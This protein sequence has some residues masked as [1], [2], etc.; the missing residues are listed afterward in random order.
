MDGQKPNVKKDALTVSRPE[1]LVDG[2][3]ATFRDF[4][5]GFLTMAR[6]IDQIRESFAYHLGVSGPQYEVLVHLRHEGGADGLSVGELA[7][8][9]HCTGAF[10]TTE[11]GKLVKKGLLEKRADST[12]GRRVRLRLTA[13][14]K[15]KLREL[16]RVQREVNDELFACVD[17]D[18]FLRLVELFPVFAQCAGRAANLA[19]YL[20]EDPAG[21]PLAGRA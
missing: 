21:E 8:A 11:A 7:A 19:R 1:L 6:L 9:M 17:R 5:H 15:R 12:D 3:D 18:T 2:S 14:G 10:A 20:V 13:L 4:V 16:A